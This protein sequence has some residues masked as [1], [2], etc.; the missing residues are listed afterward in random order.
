M[1]NV[2]VQ[3][4]SSSNGKKICMYIQCGLQYIVKSV[5]CRADDVGWL[6]GSLYDDG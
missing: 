1:C 2:F 5:W 3:V 6:A 4:E